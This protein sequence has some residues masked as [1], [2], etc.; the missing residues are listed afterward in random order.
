MSILGYKQAPGSK[1]WKIIPALSL[2]HVDKATKPRENGQNDGSRNYPETG[3]QQFA[4]TENRIVY[5][6]EDYLKTVDD[7]ANKEFTDITRQAAPLSLAEVEDDFS[8]LKLGVEKEYNQYTNLQALPELKKLRIEERRELRNFK[9]F[10]EQN[11]L[12]RLAKYPTSRLF[13]FAII[14]LC[15]AGESAANTYFFAAGTDLG[16]LGGFFSALVVS[17]ANL[18]LSFTTGVL[19]LRYMH[20]VQK[21]KAIAG[22]L[23]FAIW[24]GVTGIFHLLVAHYRDL[25][26]IDPDHAMVGAWDKLRAA[27]FGLESMESYIVMIIGLVISVI[28]LLDGYNCDDAYPGYGKADRDYRKKLDALDKAESVVRSIMVKAMTSSEEQIAERLKGYEEQSRKLADLYEGSASVVDH[29]D[30]IYQQVDEIVASAVNTYR[31]ANLRVRTDEAPVSFTRMPVVARLLSKEKFVR[32]LEE[33]RALKEET[34][35]RMGVMRKT[36]SAL[37]N[38]MARETENLGRKLDA[39]S[40]EVDQKAAAQMKRDSEEI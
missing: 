13:H 36:A 22:G 26:L 23:F 2:D 33:L 35:A 10:K 11:R 28:F 17:V 25:L 14:A 31:E 19:A 16:Y 4:E 9:L 7:I 12:Q 18:L 21:I 30:N 38:S 27:P 5:E 8:D 3:S 24:M 1:I 15:L 6:V 34:A 37:L 29:F 39:L 32:K 20:H 40:D